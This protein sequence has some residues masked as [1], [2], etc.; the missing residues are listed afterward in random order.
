MF[1]PC[2]EQLL[3]LTPSVG[4]ETEEQRDSIQR[5]GQTLGFKPTPFLF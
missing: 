2:W 5:E 1:T 4:E 3:F